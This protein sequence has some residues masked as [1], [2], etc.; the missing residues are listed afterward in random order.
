MMPQPGMLLSADEVRILLRFLIGNERGAHQRFARKNKI[1]PV[2]LSNTLA[3]RRHP[4]PRMLKVLGL[5]EQTVYTVVG[6]VTPR[7]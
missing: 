3:G 7:K 2:A 6:P 5:R 4:N 1:N